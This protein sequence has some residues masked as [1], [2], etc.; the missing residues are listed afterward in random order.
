MFQELYGYGYTPCQSAQLHQAVWECLMEELFLEIILL[1]YRAK[2][3]ISYWLLAVNFL[4]ALLPPTVFFI[5]WATL[6]RAL[7]LFWEASRAQSQRVT[8]A[9]RC[10]AR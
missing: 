7:L 8:T 6:R 1:P 3:S 4:V 10:R 5:L 2:A 9:S